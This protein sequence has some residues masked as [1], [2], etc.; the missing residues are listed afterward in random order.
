MK[1]GKRRDHA[2]VDVSTVIESRQ[3]SDFEEFACLFH[4]LGVLGQRDDLLAATRIDAAGGTLDGFLPALRS[5]SR[6]SSTP[7][8]VHRGAQFLECKRNAPAR[9]TACP[10]CQG[11]GPLQRL[12][13]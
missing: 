4:H 13:Q 12:C 5:H 1:L 11:D 3:L 8:H 10:G 9:A 2:P 6:A 7:G